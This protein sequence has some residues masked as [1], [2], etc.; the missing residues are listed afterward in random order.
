MPPHLFYFLRLAPPTPTPSIPDT[1]SLL[2]RSHRGGRTAE[3]FVVYIKEQLAKDAAFARIP[4]LTEIAQKLVAAAEG[5]RAALVAEAKQAAAELDAA[6][7]ENADL[8][9]KYM[10]KVVAKG[11]E[12]VAT[13]VARLQKLVASGMSAV[14]QTEVTR[15]IS[16][17]SSFDKELA[18]T[19]GGPE[20][21]E[22]EEAGDDG[23]GGGYGGYGDAGYAGAPMTVNVDE[24]GTATLVE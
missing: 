1:P 17:L 15:K 22:E 4:E 13:E 12:Y 16:V 7:K 21:E 5:E 24:D 9:L 11:K 20:E 18:A 10:E 2:S 6:A 23:Y 8:Y 14:K 3:E 19:T